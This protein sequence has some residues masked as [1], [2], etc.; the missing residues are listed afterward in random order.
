MRL[1]YRNRRAALLLML[2]IFGVTML[3]IKYS[4]L[5]PTCLFKEDQQPSIML[6][7]EVRNDLIYRT[8]R[9]DCQDNLMTEHNNYNIKP[10]ELV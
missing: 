2:C 9:I 7:D 10:C 8:N 6:R 3:L 4:E 1:V 5:G